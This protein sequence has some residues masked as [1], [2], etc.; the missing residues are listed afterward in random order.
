ME[1]VAR[2]SD[3]RAVLIGASDFGADSGLSAL[4]A[5]ANN[6]TRLAELF[7][8]A[9]VRGLPT[10]NIDVLGQDRLSGPGARE[11]V[12]DAVTA[13]AR[14]ARDLLVV[15]YSGHGLLDL[16]DRLHLALPGTAANRLYA[17]IDYDQLRDAIADAADAPRRVLILDCCFAGTAAGPH[18]GAAAGWTGP[19]PPTGSFLLGAAAPTEFARAVPG[20]IHTAFSGELITLLDTGVVGGG[21]WL[22][23]DE[24]TEHLDAALAAK[25]RPRPWPAGHGH[26][27]RIVLARNT[28]Y[29]PRV[30]TPDEVLVE[31]ARAQKRAADAFPYQLAGAQRTRLSTVYVRQQL[32]RTTTESSPTGDPAVPGNQ[33]EQAPDKHTGLASTSSLGPAVPLDDLLRQE[34]HLIVVGGPGQ[35]KTTLTLQ[36]AAQIAD[37]WI[38]ER[39]SGRT[40][41]TQTALLALRVAAAV[42]AVESGP[43]DAAVARVAGGELG[44]SLDR[45]LPDDLVGRHAQDGKWLVIVDG[46]DEIT[47]P[48]VRRDIVRL[49]AQRMDTDPRVRLLI[50][51]RDL[52]GGELDVLE[53]SGATR[54]VLAPFDT[55]QLTAFAHAW[56]GESAEGRR[57]SAGFLAGLDDAA[58]RELLQIPLLA[59]IAAILYGQ[60][61]DA[62]LPG[63]SYTL[64]EQYFAYLATAR[65]EQTTRQWGTIR[66]RLAAALDGDATAADQLES[67]RRTLVEYLAQRA[68]AGEVDLLA[69]A[70]SWL[71][72]HGGRAARIRVPD[73]PALVASVLNATGLFLNTSTLR[74]VHLSLAEHLAAAARARALPERFDPLD[75][76]WN[77]IAR[78]ALA[79]EPRALAVL[80]HHGHLHGGAD[81]AI[82]WLES[83]DVESCLIA[84]RL[85]ADGYPADPARI[86]H[87]LGTVRYEL[88]RSP[89]W[90]GTVRTALETT[91]RLRDPR[92]AQLLFECIR[93][94]SISASTR[95]IAIELIA[96]R[97]GADMATHLRSILG[98]TDADPAD[99][100]QVATALAELGPEYNEEAAGI[101]RGVITNPAVIGRQRLA[102]LRALARIDRTCAAEAAL[103]LESGLENFDLPPDER[104]D[105]AQA[106]AELGFGHVA[107]LADV[108]RSALSDPRADRYDQ[109]SAAQCLLGLGREFLPGAASEALL[110]MAADRDPDF[111]RREDAVRSLL[112]ADPS[113]TAQVASILQALM[114]DP[115]AHPAV[116]QDAAETLGGLG[117]AHAEQA[118]ALIRRVMRDPTAA[119]SDRR[120][121]VRALTSWGQ[122][123]ADEALA[124]LRAVF[125]APDTTISMRE[126]AGGELAE[127]QPEKIGEVID[128][129]LVLI[130][131]P[132][133]IPAS[134]V[135]MIA[136]MGELGPRYADEAA[137]FLRRL[138][139]DSSLDAADREEIGGMFA[140][141]GPL[142]VGEAGD[143]FATV[144]LDPELTVDARLRVAHKLADLGPRY[145]ETVAAAYGQV[146]AD[147][148]AHRRREAAV[149]L[150]G[151]GSQYLTQAAGYLRSLMTDAETGVISRSMAAQSLAELGPAFHAEAVEQLRA[152]IADTTISPGDRAEAADSLADI[153]FGYADEAAQALQAIAGDSQAS[154]D[155]RIRAV[156]L[157][158]GL[159]SRY[160]QEPVALLRRVLEAPWDDDAQ[161]LDAERVLCQ[162]EPWRTQAVAE[163]L[164]QTIRNDST[165]AQARQ[166]AR[167]ALASLGSGYAAEVA[168]SYLSQ[169]PAGAVDRWSAVT[170]TVEQYYT[171]GNV[172]SDALEAL[173]AEPGLSL[174]DRWQAA[175][176]IAEVSPDRVD[177]AAVTLRATIADPRSTPFDRRW[178]TVALARAKAQDVHQSADF[179]RQMLADSR[180][181]SHDRQWT[182]LALA[183]L[184]RQ[185]TDEG[186]DILLQILLDSELS[187]GERFAAAYRL[188]DLRAEAAFQ[189]AAR[190]RAV[191][192]HSQTSVFDRYWTA[193]LIAALGPEYAKDASE[194][195]RDMISRGQLD[196]DDYVRTVAGLAALDPAYSGEAA[197]ILRSAATDPKRGLVDRAM[198]AAE[199]A[200]LTPDATPQAA[201]LLRQVIADP[202]GT[203]RDREN[204][205]SKLGAL[206]PEYVLEA[207]EPLR[208]ILANPAAEPF[209]R[210]WAAL[211][212][213]HLGREYAAEATAALTALAEDPL[214]DEGD[215]ADVIETMTYIAHGNENDSAQMRRP[216]VEYPLS[217]L[218]WDAHADALAK[219]QDAVTLIRRQTTTSARGSR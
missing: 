118:A 61:P 76:A 5:V 191:C 29:R 88:R 189:A 160:G 202:A 156:Q 212:L 149:D 200:G 137:R 50:T 126:W 197:S 53:R 10:E 62:P 120:A 17:A 48:A 195:V 155:D 2:P 44:R 163:D 201:D 180:L 205:A 93:D 60:S 211:D 175:Q 123:Y 144:L 132:G 136:N 215:R 4:P 210:R 162:L 161:R 20:E 124:F 95:I 117:P 3:S 100:L 87:L 86:G 138:L 58:P 143:I 166:Q 146:A 73:W 193:R 25:G 42:L 182:A 154:L 8:D 84:G 150:A 141:L 216:S 113:Y 28:A 213:H 187:A 33:D 176:L 157:L 168:I 67:G 174:T 92:A 12:F 31:L 90:S 16:R 40:G 188:R 75:P 97:G 214:L 14:Q 111:L 206:A 41:D 103:E 39:E 106:L 102:A 164:R 18:M 173:L 46:L 171:D 151:L 24:I 184:G 99:Q 68:V 177:F 127:L 167:R 158:A 147:E 131:Q 45:A 35:G 71:D 9:R 179:L 217:H 109:W 59:T 130:G 181:D 74:F 198:A 186:A 203:I 208:E 21:P 165:D 26:G 56:F 78:Q 89:S 114:A 199:L 142:H 219:F 101:V 27:G 170:E 122:P 19:E 80:L 91:A 1:S 153:G 204:A 94:Q 159:D 134:R 63:N 30:R 125:A 36:L 69:A 72:R 145:R 43:W 38:Q 185:Y 82:T 77:E 104:V 218:D 70:V 81:E 23:M 34:N 37:R 54:C 98:A 32:H 110:S 13:A 22:T 119:I 83:G 66:A 79:D 15:Y 140:D 85:L 148:A 108:F 128:T 152:L 139:A 11:R 57:L 64:Y 49:L 121:A 116:R 6:L 192:A 190:L 133:L 105:T 115:E 129:A 172:L 65:V 107:R 52:P 207:S 169:T 183:K 196:A 47:D 112:Q 96:R 209:E 135:E 51:T 194:I 55:E 178:A 7:A